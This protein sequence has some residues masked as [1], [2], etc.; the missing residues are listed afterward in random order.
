ML[1][2]TFRRSQLVQGNPNRAQLNDPA[3]KAAIERAEALTDAPA[4][5]PVPQSTVR[6]P[7]TRL[8]FPVGGSTAVAS[9]RTCTTSP[10]ATSVNE[11]HLHVAALAVHQ[12]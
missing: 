3:I 8:R 2:P 10:T 12:G 9:R 11:A 1:D 6:S 5:A 7:P 4:R